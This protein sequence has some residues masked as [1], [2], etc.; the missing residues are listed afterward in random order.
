MS[1]GAGENVPLDATGEQL[2][3]QPAD[4]QH[5]QLDLCSEATRRSLHFRKPRRLQSHGIGECDSATS[6]NQISP[7]PSSQPMRKEAYVGAQLLFGTV[8]LPFA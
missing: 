3:A 1:H 8:V 7:S 6:S 4:E 2:D 5:E